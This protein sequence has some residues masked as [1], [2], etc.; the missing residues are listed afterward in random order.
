MFEDKMKINEKEAEDGPF[1]K[2][3]FKR[4]LLLQ[5]QFFKRSWKTLASSFSSESLRH[6]KL[7]FLV[8]HIGQSAWLPTLSGSSSNP[9]NF[10]GTIIYSKLNCHLSLPQRQ[11]GQMSYSKFHQNNLIFTSI[12]MLHKLLCSF[13]KVADLDKSGHT[14]QA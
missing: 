13:A 5:F 7:F 12:T 9:D 14:P 11:F 10:I 8:W 2:R 3:K 4:K 6:Q 1:F